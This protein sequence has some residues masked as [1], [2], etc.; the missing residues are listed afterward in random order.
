MANIK[1]KNA[2]ILAAGD[3]NHTVYANHVNYATVT[4]NHGAISVVIKS[5]SDLKRY[6]SATDSHFFE[7]DTMRFFGDSMKNYAC[8][9][10]IVE[11]K[12][13]LCFELCRKK[14][15][16]YGLKDSAFFSILTFDVIV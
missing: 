8:N 16:K 5:A 10:L 14:S 2:A 11:Y 15:V 7:R 13:V 6:V 9:G 3:I 4:N 12:S 1:E